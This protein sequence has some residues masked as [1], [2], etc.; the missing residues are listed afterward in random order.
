MLKVLSRSSARGF[1]RIG[2]GFSGLSMRSALGMLVISFLLAKAVLMGELYPFGT[3]FLAAVCITYPR[4]GKVALIG[5]MAGTCAVVDGWNLAGYLIA[6]LLIYTVL[7][8]YAKKDYHW[9]IVP[10][11]VL[12]INILVRGMEVYFFGNELY[13][14][15]EL[16]FES[17]FAGILSLVTATGL[18]AYSRMCKGGRLS[19]EESTSLGIIVLGGLVGISGIGIWNVGIQSVIS[20]W[21]VLWA[22]YLGGPGG[23]AAVGVAVGLIPSIQG[24]L[25]TGP[26]AF[27]ALAG[28]LGGVF[29]AF[30]KPGV[31][32]GFTLA[33]LLLSLFFSEQLEL[34]RAIAETAVAAACFLV[35]RAGTLKK[36]IFR[37]SNSHGSSVEEWKTELAARM[38]RMAQVFYE[39]KN[40][41]SVDVKKEN[42]NKEQDA[43]INRVAVKVCEG[44]SLRRVCW[45][46]D[47]SKTYQDLLKACEKVRESGGEGGKEFGVNIQKRC[48]RLREL[49]ITLDSEMELLRTIKNYEKE[50]ESC[51]ELVKSQVEGLGSVLEDLS[52]ELVMETARDRVLEVLLDEEMKRKGLV[53]E[54]IAVREI[55]EGIK[56][57][58]VTQKRCD[59]QSWCKTMVAP[60]ISQLMGRPYSVKRQQCCP[61]SFA[62]CCEYTLTPG[63]SYRVE[64]GSAQ[65]PKDGVQVAGDICTAFDLPDSRFV[66]VMSDGMG[67]GKEARLES[68]TAVALLEKL[69]CS[70]FSYDT[71]IK[72]INTVMLLRSGQ[73][74]FVTLDIVVVNRVNGLTDFIKIGSA[75]T[76]I[77]NHGGLTV[78]QAQA[79]PAGILDSIRIKTF[80]HMISSGNIII[81]MSDGVWDAINNAG[82]PAGWFEEVLKKINMT[83]TQRA[84]K[85]LLYLAK[86]AGGNRAGDDMCVQIA[87]IEAL[88][89]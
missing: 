23:G 4:F 43:L 49:S 70:G 19:V 88:D 74:K 20:R 2:S 26:I 34:M 48:R 62:G 73:E 87:R 17:F 33:N 67:V 14:W 27:Y 83:N 50:N 55:S 5:I 53:V 13:Q 52:K 40:S 42:G 82:G 30:A 89:D 35:L 6:Q 47:F 86:K 37:H 77:C 10:A 44:C 9:F 63:C 24:T 54:G 59:D 36:G 39:L 72:T 85:N 69:F 58:C 15:V 3:G 66:L 56:E 75:P 41:F 1:K 81:M 79:P 7:V 29:N 31:I 22:A 78:V 32:I 38:E 64:V 84:A 80:R 21:L 51:R 8:I 76:I 16:S 71:I 46:Q 57:I 60:N 18:Q 45:E 28:L 65:C 68:S 25:T 11:V 61:D 12:A